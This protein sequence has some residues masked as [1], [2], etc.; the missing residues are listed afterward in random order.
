MDRSRAEAQ[1]L[2]AVEQW[3]GDALTHRSIQGSATEIVTL[4]G[5]AFDV[6]WRRVVVT[7]GEVTLT[8]I[9]ERVLYTAAVHHR[10]LSTVSTR[11]SGDLSW[12]LLLEERLSVVPRSELIEGL[13]FTMVELLTVIGRLTAEILSHEL[14]NALRMV[15]VDTRADGTRAPTGPL[16]VPS[17][18]RSKG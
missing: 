14:H 12:K 5:A 13:R 11:P 18:V 10:F 2:A 6:V 16:P 4:F 8:A 1:H 17:A 7:L 15:R 9:A 3:L